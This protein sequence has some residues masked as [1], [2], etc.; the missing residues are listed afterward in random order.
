MN[1][2]AGAG[3]FACL[4]KV[5]K[6]CFRPETVVRRLQHC[7]ENCGSLALMSSRE[8]LLVKSKKTV[9]VVATRKHMEGPIA[10]QWG[11]GVVKFRKVSIKEL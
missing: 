5:P 1:L 8:P 4:H 10:L 3:C 6:D 11:R 2:L 7:G 9:D